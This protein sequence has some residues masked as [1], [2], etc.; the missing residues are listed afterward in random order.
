MG[1]QFFSILVGY[2]ESLTPK[3]LAIFFSYPLMFGFSILTIK[4]FSKTKNLPPQERASLYA[5]DALLFALLG[6]L[7]KEEI[8]DPILKLLFRDMFLSLTALALAVSVFSISK[9]LKKLYLLTYGGLLSALLVEFIVIFTTNLRLV[10][11][12]IPLRKGLIVVSVYPVLLALLELIPIKRFRRLLIFLLSFLTAAVGLAWELNLVDFDTKAFIG[13]AIAVVVSLLYSWFVTQGAVLLERFLKKLSL[14]DEDR[15]E[16]ISNLKQLALILLLWVYWKVAVDFTNLSP[17][18]EK[19]KGILLVDTDVVKISL[20]GILVSAFLFWFLYVSINILKKTIKL[21]F[22]PEEREEKG[23]SLEAVIYNLGILF[24]I[25]LAL[26]QL[27][28]TW[29]VILPLA[30]ALGIGL[31]FGL[32]TILNN[33]VSGFIMMFSKNIKVG[34]FVELPG[35]AGRFINNPSSTIFGRVEDISVL[36]TRIK[37]LD[38]IDI[39][40]PNSTFIGSQIIN[41]TFR[42][43][44]VRVRFPFG[45]AYSS[46]PKKVKEILLK[47]AYECPWAKNYYKPPQVWFAEMGDSALIFHLLFWVDIREI[48]RNTYAT[49]SHGLFDWVNTN[50][51]YKLKEAGIEIPF[52]QQDL[53]FRNSLKVVLEKEDGTPLAVFDK[54]NLPQKEDENNT[55]E[56][57]K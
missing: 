5:I 23:G 33:Y 43:P 3:E 35:N 28:L 31:G 18:V 52:P 19:L 8:S 20:Y 47:V 21:L 16:L 32:Q 36:T 2:I 9:G 34:D 37:T 46:D 56:G 25:T 29:K 55:R 11:I 27:G 38:G 15:G 41:Y 50:A 1:F 45:V 57:N 39:L 22:N 40:V 12:L 7:L 14:G 10:D 6:F 17:L 26:A 42:N 49:L 51:W 24:A 13:L 4:W 54:P 48:W 53:W 30:G 44:Y